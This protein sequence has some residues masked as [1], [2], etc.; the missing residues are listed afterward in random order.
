MEGA[1]RSVVLTRTS[2]GNSPYHRLR[3]VTVPLPT[4]L[5]GKRPSRPLTLRTNE[6]VASSVG[7]PPVRPEPMPPISGFPPR[8][9]DEACTAEVG[10][11]R[12]D[13]QSASSTSSRAS[14]SSSR[15]RRRHASASAV[16]WPCLS[17]F[18]LPLGGPAWAPCILHRRLPLTAGDRHRLPPGVRAPQR[19]RVS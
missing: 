9:D 2:T 4:A 17:A 10:P 13:H 11:L 16:R 15:T 12:A 6:P 8:G 18:R 3:K 1:A 5:R 14:A 7:F 19:V